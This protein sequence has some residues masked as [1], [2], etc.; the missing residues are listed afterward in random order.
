MQR[1][2]KRRQN[3][4]F[5]ATLPNDVIELARVWLHDPLQVEIAAGDP[6]SAS[7]VAQP[8]IE[9]HV[10]QVDSRRKSDLLIQLL[11]QHELQQVLVFVS[12]KKTG[13]ELETRLRRA[14]IEA[15]VFHADRSQQERTRSL[16]DFR[17]GRV[18]VL[19][20][21]DLAA[22]G[23]D[24]EAL[25]AVI[26]L[27]LP[28]SPNDYVHRIGRTGRAGRP[29]LALSLIDRT[30]EQHFRVIEKRIRRRLPRERV[31][32]FEPRD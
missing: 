2:P 18:R 1:L 28:R 31:A 19:I 4:L 22:R 26:N 11:R 12:M 25:P 9:E 8:Q 5:S 14:E 17:A 21:T 10:Y 30:E 3:L 6:V 29:G 23:L 27:E 7:A 24:I 13:N 20:A 15:A 16:A 32:G